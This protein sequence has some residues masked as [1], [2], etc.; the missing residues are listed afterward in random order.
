MKENK[1]NDNKNKNSKNTP[2]P[3]VPIYKPPTWSSTP[4][5][6]YKLDV[7]KSGAIIEALSIDKKPYYLIG[8]LPQCDIELAHPSISRQHAVI[9]HRDDGTVYV[10]DLKSTHGTKIGK[11]S[12]KPHTYCILR[13]GDMVRFGGSSRMMIL[14]ANSEAAVAEQKRL[15]IRAAKI[16]E[17]KI[18]Q[19]KE[20]EEGTS[21]GMKFDDEQPQQE[22]EIEDEEESE[23]IFSGNL[24]EVYAWKRKRQE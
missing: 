13:I 21:W 20:E 23:E 14:D 19:L 16:E 15:D 2:P 7:L 17:Q 10:Y 6:P 12:L 18:Q 3:F 22:V 24:N 5:Y 8:R 4:I 11:I 9:Q 1:N